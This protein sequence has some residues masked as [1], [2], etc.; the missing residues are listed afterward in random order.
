MNATDHNKAYTQA[1]ELLMRALFVD[2][3]MR[4]ALVRQTVQPHPES[5]NLAA[6]YTKVDGLLLKQDILRHQLATLLDVTLARVRDPRQPELFMFPEAF[7]HK[8]SQDA[9]G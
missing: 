7:A 3:D 8:T 1:T 6:L 4:L 2:A 5:E 9:Q